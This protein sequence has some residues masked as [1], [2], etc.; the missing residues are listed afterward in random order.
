MAALFSLEAS[1]REM[2]FILLG[3]IS[4]TSPV[5][6][7][8]SPWQW[9]AILV[10]FLGFFLLFLTILLFP[11]GHFVPRWTRFVVVVYL[12]Q[13][14]SYNFFPTVTFQL[15]TWTPVLGDFS[16]IG[17]I[18]ATVAAQVYRYRHV[19]NVV[20]RQQTKWVVFGFA[21]L[22]LSNIGAT[23]LLLVL[24]PLSLTSFLISLAFGSDSSFI[25]LV[26]PLSFGIA[27]LRYRLWD[28]D[29][30]INRTL[31]YGI[32]T[33]CVFGVYTL[34]VGYMSFLFQERYTLFA[35]LLAT[36]L[37]AL[38]FQPLREWLQRSMN[39]IM[40]G[41]RDD[42][43][44]VIVRLGQRLEATLAPDAMLP[45][46]VETVAQALKLPYAA[47]A[48]NHDAG[49]SIAACYGTPSGGLVHL[50]LVYQGEQIG[51][52]VLAPRA[53]GESFTTTDRRLLDS[54][55]RQAEVAAHTVHLTIDLQRLTHELQRSRGQMVTTR[56]EERRRLRRDL[57]DGLGSVLA[58]LNWRAGAI[59]KLLA[60]DPP[61]ADAL[62][63]EQQS[64]IRSA[65][66]DIRHLVYELR[67]PSL[68]ELGLVGAIQE[69]AAQESA[70]GLSVDIVI[71]ENLP[72]L[73]AA[74][75]VAAYR[76]IQEALVNVIRHA[77]AHR[78]S[79]HL[80]VK[81][82][83][84]QVE[85]VDD[86]IGLKT[87]YRAGVGLLSMRERAEELGGRWEIS[88]SQGGGTK[89]SVNIPLGNVDDEE[90]R[91]EKSNDTFAHFD[92]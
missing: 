12:L 88:P 48:L 43:Y 64:T 41:D 28:I 83:L 89:V 81:Q 78:C 91:K 5:A 85:I 75:E 56:E 58:S 59:R 57:H 92:R 80:E 37:V 53:P 20:Q 7:I 39:R 47:I 63:G 16:W 34:F 31:V 61:A 26:I 32:L 38:L 82:G 55:A 86:G 90:S 15:T 18:L 60:L 19:S 71:P 29:L 17:I 76:I 49:L 46:I 45:V 9:S 33:I 52:L 62:V 79:V 36:G 54:L 77:H 14:V 65:I 1:E 11:D 10:N 84:L 2:R 22:L 87:G 66:A 68:D 70:S 67:P 50:P 69:R 27:I 42:P 51:E 73:S 74:V 35:S 4:V 8:P 21:V 13:S 6:Q 40:Y 72:V 3:A 25:L 24:P 30:L 44:R 23:L